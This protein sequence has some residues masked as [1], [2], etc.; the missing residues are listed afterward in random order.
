MSGAGFRHRK[1]A[2][3]VVKETIEPAPRL[4]D[5][6]HLRKQSLRVE[7]HHPEILSATPFDIVV[8]VVD[9]EIDRLPAAVRVARLNVAS[10]RA[11]MWVE[12][13]APPAGARAEQ[14]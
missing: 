2:V 7:R 3:R 9:V 8:I 4:F 11:G 14:H 10:S 13:V 1:A 12:Q 5:A 6:S